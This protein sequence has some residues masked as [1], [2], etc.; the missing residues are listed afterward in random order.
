MIDRA[1]LDVA[2][3]YVVTASNVYGQETKMLQINVKSRR[4]IIRIPWTLIPPQQSASQ[5]RSENNLNI[6][7]LNFEFSITTDNGD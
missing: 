5:F 7:L 4:E 6:S 2:G 1:T 3:L